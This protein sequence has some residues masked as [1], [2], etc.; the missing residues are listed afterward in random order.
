MT[1]KRTQLSVIAVAALAIVAVAAVM[2][3]SASGTQADTTAS[4]LDSA[5]PGQAGDP[6]I[7]PTT[8]PSTTEPAPTPTPLTPEPCPGKRG[9]PNTEAAPVV[10]SGHYA[11]FDVFWDDDG[12]HDSVR[13]K[14][15]INNPCPPVATH[16]A[17]EV[18]TR[19]PSAIDIDHPTAIHIPYSA[20]VTLVNDGIA[21]GGQYRVDTDGPLWSSY[22]LEATKE[23]WVVPAFDHDA[24]VRPPLS[25]GFSA[26]LLRTAYWE[27]LSDET[28]APTVIEYHFEAV[29]APGVNP[30]DRG[31]V[32]ASPDATFADGSVVWDTRG[33]NTDVVPVAPG[34]YRHLH[35]AFT[36]PGT[37][38]LWV[39]ARGNPEEGRLVPD[40]PE[41]DSVTSVVV[42]YTF[43]VGLLADVSV[44]ISADRQLADPGETVEF[45]VTVRNDGPND[46]PDTKVQVT[47]PDGFTNPTVVAGTT[48]DP[49]PSKGGYSDGVWDIGNLP[50]G[51]SETLRVSATVD[52]G[53]RGDALAAEAV[54]SGTETIGSTVVAE[55]DLNPRNNTATAT[56]SG[57]TS[58]NVN[59]I[60]RIERT[61]GENAATGDPVGGPALIRDSDD[62]THHYTIAGPGADNFQ[63]NNAGQVSVAAGDGLNYECQTAYP[64]ELQVSD[65]KD[66]D[67][68]ADSAI[69]QIIGLDVLVSDDTGETG[70]N[71]E[72]SIRASDTTPKVGETVTLT[73]VFSNFPKCAPTN[74]EYAWQQDEG[75]QTQNFR[76]NTRQVTRTQHTAVTKTYTL[77]GYLPG[78]GTGSS[79]NFTKTITIDWGD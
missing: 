72:V 73:A 49:N 36:K 13:E 14:T 24:A 7:V 71:A 30:A 15:L 34:E 65:G 11:L 52:A 18:T 48:S 77:T 58:P 19:S 54:I 17:D 27:P 39:H 46:S 47:L 50:N 43:H 9:N 64:L 29:R 55:L 76:E 38:V 1:T 45:T 10:S 66:A 28:G 23:A 69:D 53:H 35:W 57:R 51:D 32:F 2:L 44:A 68:N 3:L 5:H 61:V 40:S 8:P 26:G 42:H 60:F 67:G 25:F 59:P 62:A 75:G 74:S 56:V 22:P 4:L 37:Y 21:T 79:T 20:K 78:V 6:Q 31:A 12:E 70:A 41:I 16:G 63:V 33:V